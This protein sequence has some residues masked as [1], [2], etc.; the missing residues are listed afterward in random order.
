[1]SNGGGGGVAG[2]GGGSSQIGGGS[3]L[4]RI[5]STGVIAG[6]VLLSRLF[7]HTTQTVEYEGLDKFLVLLRSRREVSGR[8][9]GL[10]TVSNHISVLDDPLLFAPLPLPL[11]LHPPSIRY[12]LGSHDVCFRNGLTST[13]FALGQVL[14]TYRLHKSPLGGPFQPA[15]NTSI[16]LLSYPHHAW[17]HV[18][19][20][21]RVHQKRN[22]Q[23]RYF[24]WGVSRLLLEAD[25]P[26]LV[27]PIFITGLDEVMHEAR[28]WPRFV[29]RVGKK[30][31][32]CFGD[33]V[34]GGRWEGLRRE[35]REVVH[36]CGGDKER[37]RCA[38][39]A[40]ELR[41]RTAWE[42]RMAVV[43]LRR[44][45][46][47]P[48]EEDGAGLVETY[49]LPGMRGVQGELSDGAWERDGV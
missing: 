21:G 30:V 1:M 49:K 20:E 23:M 3:L 26:P 29:P 27:V 38:D 8:R 45:L 22:Y 4:R 31:R 34:D 5:A 47:F 17:V 48:E 16:T 19:P 28:R 18:F 12:S 14:P 6:T 42:V 32:I 33:P 37:L 36:E 46:G 10:V 41:V 7:L 35:W 25:V 13:Y 9:Q 11:L 40:V 2:G 43:E 39:K 15:I 44:R 24:R